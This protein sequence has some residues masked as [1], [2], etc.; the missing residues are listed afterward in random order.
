MTFRQGL[1]RAR[2]HIVF[3][4]ALVFAF[5]LIIYLDRLG[6]YALAPTA[7]SIIRASAKAAPTGGNVGLTPTERESAIIAWQYF[8]NN[9]QPQTGLVNSADGYPSTTMWDQA[10]YLLALISAHR[11]K[12][13][14]DIVFDERMKTILISLADIPLFEGKLPNK[15]YS[16]TT[17]NMT[18]YN[19]TLTEVGIGWS[20]LDIARILVPMNIIVW[21]YPEYTDDIKNITRHWRLEAMLE[22]GIMYGTRVNESG[23]TERVQEGRIGYEEYA[24][25]VMA[26]MGYDAKKAAEYKDYLELVSI[27]GIRV[28]T[29]RRDAKYFGAHNYVVSEP[30]I[31]A[32]LEYGWT[33]DMKEYAYRVYAAQEARYKEE[34]QLTAVSEDHIDRPPYF[35]YNT[36]FSNGKV[37]NAITEEGE[38]A[39]AFRSISTK[40]A[41]GWDAIYD[42]PYTNLLMDAVEGLYDP[43]KGF[44]SGW[45]ETMN[46][47]N[48]AITANTN[49]IILQ[50][51][52]YKA[53]GKLVKLYEE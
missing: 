44:Y 46:E 13:I 16:T 1:L 38:D 49:G 39:S 45:Y 8:E 24:A 35:V 31:L 19:N 15:A 14:D 12:I 26:L 11:L 42:N 30:F 50:S 28:P 7:P 34:N 41:F 2:S 17:L 52:H 21:N 3:I 20:A 43:E 29:D 18:D 48:K 23:E 5:T 37:W 27:Y 4:I 6:S 22:E 36:V 32:E 9:L 33:S 53:H 10:S 40:A 25:T 47:A 51:L